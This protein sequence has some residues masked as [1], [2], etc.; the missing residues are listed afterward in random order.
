LNKATDVSVKIYD[1]GGKVVL[2]QAAVNYRSGLY[3][4]GLDVSALANGTYIV[5]LES[6]AG[7]LARH[8]MAVAR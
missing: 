7:V 3:Q 1:L 5:S 4:Y 6:P 2:S 8:K